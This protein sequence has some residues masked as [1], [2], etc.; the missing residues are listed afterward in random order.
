MVNFQ[1]TKSCDVSSIHHFLL[2]QKTTVIFFLSFEFFL[3]VKV[4]SKRFLNKNVKFQ[5]G[6]FKFSIRMHFNDY[7]A[8]KMLKFN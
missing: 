8:M 1:E 6:P 3:T 5:Q 2:H 4:K 7:F